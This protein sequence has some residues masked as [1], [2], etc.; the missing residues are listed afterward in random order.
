MG[1]SRGFHPFF[2]FRRTTAPKP[3]KPV[4]RRVK[5]AGSGVVVVL[6]PSIP[7]SEFGVM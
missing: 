5:E 7:A 2:I 3:T 4:P 1:C 6:P